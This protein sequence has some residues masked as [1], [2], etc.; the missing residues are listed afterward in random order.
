MQLSF[1]Q[2]LAPVALRWGDPL[3]RSFDGPH[4]QYG[5]VGRE[6]DIPASV[7]D[8]SSVTKLRYP[9]KVCFSV[10]NSV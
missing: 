2:L 8:R 10:H 7:G 5:L 1:G 6:K 3:Y 9:S 4:K